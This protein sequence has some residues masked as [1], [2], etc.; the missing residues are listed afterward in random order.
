MFVTVQKQINH[1]RRKYEKKKKCSPFLHPDIT[2][3]ESLP[4]LLT[5]VYVSYILTTTVELRVCWFPLAFSP[6]NLLGLLPIL[7]QRCGGPTLLTSSAPGS[8]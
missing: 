2:F 5:C 8:K 6:L 1:D 7:A 3:S 4:Y